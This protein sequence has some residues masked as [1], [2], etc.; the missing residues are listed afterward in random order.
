MMKLWE[1]HRHNDIANLGNLLCG[2]IAKILA[3]IESS[4]EES[5]VFIQFFD[6]YT[7]TWESHATE[8][9]KNANKFLGPLRLKHTKM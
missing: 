9:E 2:I 8:I 6:A 1:E 7:K 5:D 3:K 4:A